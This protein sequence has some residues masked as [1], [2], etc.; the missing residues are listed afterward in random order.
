MPLSTR[1]VSFHF[2]RHLSAVPSLILHNHHPRICIPSF[3]STQSTLSIFISYYTFW[4]LLFFLLFQ[5]HAC[6]FLHWLFVCCYCCCIQ[7]K[8][9]SETF[10]IGI[11][12]NNRVVTDTATKPIRTTIFIDVAIFQFCTVIVTVSRTA[13]V[14]YDNLYIAY[15]YIYIYI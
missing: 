13:L 7:R 14:R 10:V 12:S 4:K 5:M 15:I 11:N 8:T 3:I 2:R 1:C 6:I 9:K